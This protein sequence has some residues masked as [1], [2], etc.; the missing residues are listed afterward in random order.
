MYT[1][2]LLPNG[3]FM[4][5]YAWLSGRLIAVRVFYILI[6]WDIFLTIKLNP[7]HGK[8]CSSSNTPVIGLLQTMNYFVKKKVITCMFQKC[9]TNIGNLITVFVSITFF[10]NEEFLLSRKHNYITA[11]MLIICSTHFYRQ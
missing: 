4:S 8:F 2:Y 3:V 11:I 6:A 1:T 5:Y 10:L 9:T 7:L